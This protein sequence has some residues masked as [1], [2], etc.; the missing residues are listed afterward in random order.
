MRTIIFIIFYFISYYTLDNNMIN[1]NLFLNLRLKKPIDKKEIY[2]GIDISHYQNK[3][4]YNKLDT[5]DFVICKKSEGISI[6]DKCFEKNFD[7]IKCLKGA[8]HF[9]RPEC[10]GKTQAEFFLNDLNINELDIKPVIDVEFCYTW[11]KQ[12]IDISIKN[13]LEMLNYIENKL[14]RKP[15]IYTSPNFWNK[16]LS[17]KIDKNNNFL[18][19][20]ADYRK[21]ESPEI[22]KGFKDWIIWQ[23]TPNYKVDGINGNVDLNICKN[24]DSITF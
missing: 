22:P 9:F 7:S 17:N 13:L 5:L 15:I 24:I 4:E 19:W 12:K 6:I 8:Y 1:D 20:I 23:K 21:S 10:D 2:E 14:G 18:L 3:I 16:Y 11:N